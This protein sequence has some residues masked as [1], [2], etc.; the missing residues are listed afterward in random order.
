[1]KTNRQARRLPK[2]TQLMAIG[3]A[4]AM[5][6]LSACGSN[7]NNQPSVCTNSLPT[8]PPSFSPTLTLPP[9][10]NSS[11]WRPDEIAV[12]VNISGGG[13]VDGKSVAAALNHSYQTMYG[14]TAWEEKLGPEA[15]Y[16]SPSMPLSTYF[17]AF[18]PNA[19]VTIPS[20]INA[21]NQGIVSEGGILIDSTAY[22]IA[23]SPDWTSVGSSW[24]GPI[25]GSPSGPYQQYS[26][27]CIAK[28]QACSASTPM[29]PV[30]VLDTWD[31][32]IDDAV[33]NQRA[34]NSNDIVSYA[35]VD[36]PADTATIT[37][38]STP[39]TDEM[40]HGL[41][42]AAI[43]HH[44]APCAEIHEIPVLNDYG[45]GDFASL[46]WGLDAVSP[47]AIAVNLSLET[48]AP[49][50][51]LLAVWNNNLANPLTS[52]PD[53]ASEL[54]SYG[55]WQQLLFVPLLAL[56]QGQKNLIAAAGNDG[57]LS[58]GLPA[59]ICGVTAVGSSNGSSMSGFSN[60][61]GM[62]NPAANYTGCLQLTQSVTYTNP[63]TQT[64]VTLPFGVTL[65][66]SRPATEMTQAPGDN[67][68]SVIYEHLGTLAW[69]QW[70]GTSFST[71]IVTGD[72]AGQATDNI[73]GQT[74]SSA[75]A[76]TLN[77]L[78]CA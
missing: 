50:D 5:S 56:I 32:R 18:T 51:V 53:F 59:A 71:A 30:Y 65:V 58:A 38:S 10:A 43:I 62:K 3:L 14:L 1:M 39:S 63:T 52:T 33:P 64:L 19:N 22:I 7:S 34:T 75:T 66:S 6:M 31:N 13:T 2:W 72:K 47:G 4:V 20:F 60:H 26:P 73:V 48:A 35:I 24:R 27:H 16:Q 25:A 54:V 42:I 12:T 37:A 76:Q 49:A 45:A 70:R 69:A 8:L 55:P 67:V 9:S 74:Y 44:L 36:Q 28:Q 57:G 41:Y 11:Y 46:A 68:C 23:A 77:S 15:G 21:I 29:Q 61:T 40:P 17:L 78:P